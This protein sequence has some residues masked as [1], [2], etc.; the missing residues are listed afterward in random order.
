[1]QATIKNLLT[2]TS[3]FLTFVLTLAIPLVSVAQQG[4]YFGTGFNT[5]MTHEEVRSS[6]GQYDFSHSTQSKNDGFLS[7]SLGDYGV[8][9][10]LGF[11]KNINA[12]SGKN[13]LTLDA[14]YYYNYQNVTLDNDF[15]A[16][17]IK[18]TAH[19][20]HGYRLAL[21]HHFGMIHPY[22]II[23][24]IYQN[25]SPY[26]SSIDNDG[27]IYDVDDDGTI[28]DTTLKTKGDSFSTEVFSFIGGF[29][30][31][32]PVHP[33]WTVNVEYIPMKHVEYGLRSVSNPDNYFANGLVINQLHVGFRYFLYDPFG[34]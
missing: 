25:I 6:D 27:I 18:T 26:N 5:Y 19:Y 4:F 32:V 29:G 3:L 7:Q 34:K 12:P 28:L 20:N 31:E 15:D 1:M 22:L 24:G 23:Q 8:G 21:G 30:I 17:R 11:R 2:P 14:Q 16:F 9:L 13:I 10:S 33:K